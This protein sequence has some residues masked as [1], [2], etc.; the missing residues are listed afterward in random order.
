MIRILRFLAIIL[1]VTIIQNN[2]FATHNRAGEI[3]VR[4]VGEPC[5]L[6]VE[7][8][9]ITYTKASSVAADRDTLT[10]CWGDG[11]CEE[12]ARSN[13]PQPDPSK[14]KKGE[15]RP[16][17]IKYN[18]YIATHTYPGRSRYKISM[19][20]PNRNGGILNVNPPGSENVQF[21]LQTIYSFLNPQFQGCNDTPIL[22]QPPIDI[23]CKG[24]PFIHNPNA[25][26]PDKDSLSY[27]LVTPLQDVDTPVPNYS[28]PTQVQGNPPCCLTLNERTGELIWDNPQKLGEY[29]IAMIIIS[30]RNGV[31]I[32]TVLRD[33]QIFVEDC[34]ENQPPVIET[35]D[36]LCVVAGEEIEFLVRATDPDVG[37]RIRL[38]ALGG[39]FEVSPSPAE[40]KDGWDPFQVEFQNQPNQKSFRWQTTCDHIS[41]QYYQIVFKAVDNYFDTTGLAD[42][43]TVRIKVVGPPPEDVQADPNSQNI[44]VTWEKP[45]VCEETENDYFF[46]FSVWRRE[47]SK[48]FDID[49]CDPGLNGKGYTRIKTNTID[50]VDD[51]Y[52]FKDE[53]VERGRTYC[54]RILARF[55]SRTSSGQAYNVVES[56]ASDEVCVQLSRDVPLLTNVSVLET[57]LN[58]GR[59]SIKWVK[60][61]A[62]DL[63]TLDNPGPYTY[64]ILRA[65][66]ITDDINQFVRIPGASFTS[67]TYWELTAD[68]YEDQ[69]LNTQ[70]SPYSYTIAF[71]VNNET[72]PLGYAPPASSVF[73]NIA[74]TDET[75]NISW[76]YLT[77]WEN[78]KFTIYRQRQNSTVFDSIGQTNGEIFSDQGL[79]N[80][81]EYCYYVET[82]GSY[83]VAGLPNP[84]IN[85][86]QEA[87]GV[88]LD[89]IPPCPPLL[90]VEDICS[91][92]LDCAE[93]ENF[94][95][96]LHWTNPMLLCEETDDVVSYRVY[97]AQREGVEFEL[98][99]EID[100]SGDTTY[101]HQPE[102]G[103]IGCYAVTAL[104]TFLN[105]SAFSNIECV[106][107]CPIYDLANTF[108]PNNDGFN[109][110]YTPRRICFVEKVEMQIFNRWGQLVYE[111]ED[112]SLDWDGSNLNGEKLPDGTYYYVCNVFEQSLTGISLYETKKGFIDIINNTR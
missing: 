49:K 47:G 98:I 99:A 60:P 58:A 100:N 42:L 78:Q 101:F 94:E 57:D 52:Y 106:S 3:I 62:E 33:M 83:G 91:K 82:S 72:E 23:A 103:I 67:D 107:S 19:T 110:L 50:V 96:D 46:G 108:T 73:L 102:N 65:D 92:G 40:D 26:D 61:L 34:K 84:L 54:Y 75:N 2:I 28:F 25:F 5:G 89:T 69:N 111:T 53:D 71:Y 104:D 31:A 87:C 76:D 68:N 85:L 55:A 56:L 30:W 93:L 39:P 45:Y 64:E 41:N 9:I 4:Q 79:V 18:L 66:G 6:T 17:D 37:D 51:R 43:K 38:S 105:E 36:E 11:Q 97:Y 7:A 16:N 21:H 109:D 13:G 15:I 81:R 77:P 10:I 24:Q 70:D 80:G 63:D 48:T 12:V 14:A 88:P 22:L 1:F 86:S 95:N 112:P 35:I 32:D 29:N 90:T 44:E 59:M 8:T 74:S 20:D 27:Q